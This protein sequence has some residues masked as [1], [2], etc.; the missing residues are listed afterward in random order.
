MGSRQPL[1]MVGQS[2]LSRR[3]ERQLP[4]STK[5]HWQ[6][7]GKTRGGRATQL[8][9]TRLCGLCARPRRQQAR[10]LLFQNRIAKS[11]DG[12]RTR[13]TR[14]GGPTAQLLLA[15]LGPLER[16]FLLG[17]DCGSNLSSHGLR[18]LDDLLTDKRLR[19]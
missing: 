8:A 10:D 18:P 1:P 19:S 14:V 15:A 6:L 16:A 17:P 2:V 9:S 11:F 5:L 7:V 12:P 3:A 13:Q 4:P